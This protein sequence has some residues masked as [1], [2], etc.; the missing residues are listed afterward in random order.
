MIRLLGF[1]LFY[2]KGVGVQVFLNPCKIL[3]KELFF[4]E[5]SALFTACKCN[6]N[7]VPRK[8]FSKIFPAS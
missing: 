3:V 1:L 2:L 5:I 6:K 8:Y 7:E 4:N